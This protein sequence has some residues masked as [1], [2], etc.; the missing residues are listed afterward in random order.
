MRSQTEIWY[1]A[2]LEARPDWAG[3][4]ALHHGSLERE[5]RDWVEDGLR[6]ERLR[7]VVCTSSLDLGVDFAPV[8]Q[9][10]QI[11]SP[12]G[13]ARLLQR[14]GRSGHRPGAVSRAVVVPTQALELVEAAAT[15]EA[16]AARAIE[17]RAPVVAPLDV[18]V[19][20]LVTCALG[21]GFRPD[22]LLAEVRG[23]RA[24]AGL[25]DADWQ[26]ALDFVL[27]GGASLNAYPEYRRVVIGDDGVAR[28]PDAR[29]AR[30]HRIGIGTIVSEAS[31]TVRVPERQGA[32]PRRGGIHRP[33]RARATASSFAG[34]VL[35]LVRVRELTAWVKPASGEGRAG[36]A[37]DR[38]PDGAVDR[39]SPTPRAD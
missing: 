20:H 28:V 23:T 33:P 9:V 16:A 8:D 11:G 21:G 36:P 22:A 35:E 5:V 12:K 39:S 38:R 32:G 19:Q 31:I 13:V 37:L 18:L 29:I 15:R 1:Q 24:Y 34:R 14:A 26:F 17:A 10:L 4:I 27:H 3:T 7:A 25:T 30:R 2:L 6:D